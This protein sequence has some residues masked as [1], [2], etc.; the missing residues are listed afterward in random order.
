MAGNRPNVEPFALRI[1][2]ELPSLEPRAARAL[3]ELLEVLEDVE[4]EDDTEAVA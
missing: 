2:D 3:L 1:P 4:L